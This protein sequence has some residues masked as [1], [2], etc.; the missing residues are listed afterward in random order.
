MVD[1]Y[2]KEFSIEKREYPRMS[3]PCVLR[4]RRAFAV[5]EVT[6]KEQ[7]NWDVSLSKNISRKGIL[8]N[9][10]YQ[11]QPGDVL[12]VT[13]K[14]SRL[15]KEIICYCRVIRSGYPTATRIFCQ[16]AVCIQRVENGMGDAFRQAI[17]SSLRNKN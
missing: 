2:K 8:F 1:F 3:D 12:E 6:D 17:E 15:D 16:T 13:I 10:S 7:A 5:E 11:Y 9:S 4:F 14:N